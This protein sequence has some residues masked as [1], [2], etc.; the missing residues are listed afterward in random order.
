MGTSNLGWLESRFHFS[1]A[2]YYNP[3][4]INFGCL[5]VLNDDIIHPDS[6]FDTHPHENMEIVTYITQGE[7]TH[8]DSMG[9]EETLTRGEVQY[10][11]AGDGIFHSE[12]NLN[13]TKDLKLLQIWILPPKKGLPRLYG[14]HRFKKE[15]RENK[16]LNIVSSQNGEAP[17]K[18]YQDVNFYVSELDSSKELRYEINPN[19]Q[20]Y[21]VQI[22]GS[23]TVNEIVL[24]NGDACE[25]TEENLLKINAIENSHFLFIEMEKR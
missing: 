5:R 9:N 10:L 3:Q 16:L 20:I 13:K 21:F 14:S 12:H 8:K 4:N 24:E 17:I 19:R 23:S 25:I 2:Q 15:E 1:F 7:L 11:S 22:E 6:G 18:I